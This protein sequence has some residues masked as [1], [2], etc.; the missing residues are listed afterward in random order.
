MTAYMKAGAILLLVAIACFSTWKVD[1]WR[2]GKQLAEQSAA[3]QADLTAISNAAADQ[4]RTALDK[5][6]AAEKARDDLDAK[7]TQEKTHDLAEN[8][9]LRRAVADGARR[10]RIAANCRAGGGDVS[11]TASTTSLGN[12]GTIE[13][14][15]AAGRTVFD[16]RAGIIADQAALKALQAYVMSVCR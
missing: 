10:L 14:A 2:Y 3:Y 12:G 8:E 6:Q 4:V 9:T 5:Q 7:A 15:P 11:G 13:L 16:I 1:A